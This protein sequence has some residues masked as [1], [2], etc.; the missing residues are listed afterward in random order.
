MI[1]FVIA[2]IAV[3]L[4][5]GLIARPNAPAPSTPVAAPPSAPEQAAAPQKL[6][7][8]YAAT[9]LTRADDGHFYADLMVN[10]TPVHFLVDTGATSIALTREDAQKIGLQ[11]SEGEF[12]ARAQTASG[13]VGLKPVLLDRVTLGPLEATQV[14]A[15]IVEE[16]LGQSLLGQSWLKQVGTVTIEND[17]MMLR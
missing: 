14:E 15:A 8:G 6:G 9:E 13:T 4:T 7:N 12:T 16:G 11:F 1:R 3:A 10:G 5:V 2:T 17:K